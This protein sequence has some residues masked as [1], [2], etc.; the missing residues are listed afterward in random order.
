MSEQQITDVL[1]L[2]R[3]AMKRLDRFKLST[4]EID[5][6]RHEIQSLTPKEQDQFSSTIKECNDAI[7]RQYGPYMPKEKPLSND[8]MAER[9]LIMDDE[10]YNQFC[11][12]WVDVANASSYIET[13]E[14]RAF[15]D[16]GQF[17][18]GKPIPDIWNYMHAE[19]QQKLLARNN[20]DLS[21]AQSEANTKMKRAIIIHE[22]TH[23]YQDELPLWFIESH[24]YWTM[25]DILQKENWGQCST[26]D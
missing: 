25:R 7:I 22:T 4:E 17:V 13:G 6:I 21:R 1:L 14:M 3:I 15:P 19:S 16:K 20:N 18:I 9:Y 5:A 10:T 26:P 2:G 11:S 23:L 24:A 12:L 8:K